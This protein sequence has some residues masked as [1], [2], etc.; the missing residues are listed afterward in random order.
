MRFV[1]SI[2]LV[3]SSYLTLHAQETGQEEYLY[4]KSLLKQEKFGLA[5]QA[6]KQVLEL[7]DTPFKE[8]ASFYFAYCA[9]K[10]EQE[11]IAYNM[12]RQ[13]L[14][15]YP[16]WKQNQEVLFWLSNISYSRGEVDKALEL[17]DRIKDKKLKEQIAILKTNKLAEVDSL[18]QLE[19][20]YKQYKDPVIANL[21][22]REYLN[23][24]IENQDRKRINTLI[25]KHNLSFEKLGLVT[26]RDSNKK[27]K[28]KV[29]VFLPFQY[30]T[31][32]H[33]R[34]RNNFA[35][36]LF[37]GMKIAVDSLKENGINL[38]LIAFDTR[39]DSSATA[40]IIPTIG[41]VDL[42][43]GPLFTGPRKAISEY[44]R[45]NRVNMINPL[46][47]NVDI[48]GS[49]PFSFL[50]HASTITK[51]K[52]AADY[53]SELF[54]NK[55]VLII[56][57]DSKKDV[58]A[59]LFYRGL[60]EE[61]GYRVIDV[62]ETSVQDSKKIR[63]V[64]TKTYYDARGRETD[65]LKIQPDSIGHI[66]IASDNAQ[67]GANAISAIA[68][69]GDKIPVI[70]AADWL[71]YEFFDIEQIERESI[72]LLASNFLNP[73]KA[74]VSDFKQRYLRNT[75]RVPS[76]MILRGYEFL[77]FFGH[78]LDTYGTY[79]QTG[80]SD[81]VYPLAFSTGINFEGKNDNQFIELLKVQNLDYVSVDVEDEA[82]LYRTSETEYKD[83]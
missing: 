47:D 58:K 26:S 38:E 59:A 43:V 81:K 9:Y 17:E 10:D 55:N 7:G 42:I 12:F 2:V 48:I 24:P 32:Y 54:S 34:P 65:S 4:A 72:Y 74:E 79:W 50:F 82:S 45:K 76:E 16:S 3:L 66:F 28:Y 60:M 22:V 71:N 31:T 33:Y 69:R 5:R 49:N 37:E 35:V 53:A 63:K 30:D 75:K 83:E 15:R 18:E 51:A 64:L 40:R 8:Y 39:G 11:D 62:I 56:H 70:G 1:F 13:V 44:S 23:E 19:A 27:D 77:I 36:D 68:Q 29:A 57:E 46:S 61:R 20:L 52:K 21:L 14:D 67:I 78:E 80:I 73:L 25:G 6:F 41:K